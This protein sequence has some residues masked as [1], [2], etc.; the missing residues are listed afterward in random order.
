MLYCAVVLECTVGK[1]HGQLHNS[2]DCSKHYSVDI[3]LDRH[4]P[5]PHWRPPLSSLLC[6]SL[7]DAQPLGQHTVELARRLTRCGLVRVV[8]AVAL[9]WAGSHDEAAGGVGPCPWAGVLEAQRKASMTAQLFWDGCD[10]LLLACRVGGNLDA[11]ST[12]HTAHSR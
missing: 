2:T 5:H 9:V 12:Q 10:A 6:S 7:A 3:A 4:R 11:H 8:V 1:K